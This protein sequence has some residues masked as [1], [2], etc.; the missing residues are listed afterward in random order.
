LFTTGTYPNQL[1]NVAVKGNF[2]F[3]PNVAA[4]PTGPFR[5]DVNTHSLLSVIDRATNT[6]TG[7]TLNMHLAVGQQTNP[8][9][10]FNTIPW[11][12]AFKHAAND[13][14]VVIAASNI[15]IKVNSTP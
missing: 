11:A 12:I 4:S 13:G 1:N 5:F 2:A 8:V 6:D 9:K 14:Y 10:L 3:I 15:V 7:K